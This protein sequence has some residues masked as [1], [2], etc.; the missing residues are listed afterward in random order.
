MDTLNDACQP[1]KRGTVECGGGFFFFCF[2]PNQVWESSGRDARWKYVSMTIPIEDCCLRAKRLRSLSISQIPAYT[3]HYCRTIWFIAELCRDVHTAV[4]IEFHEPSCALAPIGVSAIRWY[5][6][7][8]GKK[9][10]P[11]WDR[12]KVWHR[13]Q[14]LVWCH[15]ILNMKRFPNRYRQFRANKISCLFY[16]LSLLVCSDELKQAITFVTS[17]FYVALQML[18]N[19]KAHIFHFVSRTEPI[20]FQV[21]PKH[22]V[23]LIYFSPAEMWFDG[24][25]AKYLACGVRARKAS[26][27]VA[28]C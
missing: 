19:T 20:W 14:K 18:N 6:A 5:G 13:C 27:Y 12:M 11:E 4:A 26:Y 2:Y 7:N 25:W 9:N 24:V 21:C 23:S 17:H 3:Q 8:S 28:A 16:S 10:Q 22:P 1:P 15:W